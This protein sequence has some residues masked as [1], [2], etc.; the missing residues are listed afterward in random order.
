[1]CGRGSHCHGEFGGEVEELEVFG[2]VGGSSPNLQRR[3]VASAW[4]RSRRSGA[5]KSTKPCQRDAQG[6]KEG[7]GTRRGYRG[8]TG[9]LIS[10]EDS[11]GS[12]KLRRA[13]CAAWRL[14]IE[15]GMEGKGEEGVGFIGA[16]L[17]AN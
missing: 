12:Q 9:V 8:L 2:F 17:M 10:D 3:M 1:M 15:R 16:V 13:I 5:R 6:R 11:G 4:G 14:R 7:A